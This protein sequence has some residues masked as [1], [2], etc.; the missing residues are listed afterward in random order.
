MDAVAEIAWVPH[1]TVGQLTWKPKT[2]IDIGGEKFV[3]LKP[4]DYGLVH[5]IAGMAHADIRDFGSRPTIANC[6]GLIELKVLR[7][8]AQMEEMQAPADAAPGL[9]DSDELAPSKKRQKL[10]RDG[11]SD[12]EAFTVVVDEDSPVVMK[13]PQRASEDLVIKLDEESLNNA[14][15]FMLDHGIVGDNLQNR[16]QYNRKSAN[17]GDQGPEPADSESVAEP[18]ANGL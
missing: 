3:Q 11:I 5:L 12:P 7:N 15:R 10:R 17:S 1:V 18:G 13:R 14:F 6:Q 9:F 2:I 16:R 4:A 8:T